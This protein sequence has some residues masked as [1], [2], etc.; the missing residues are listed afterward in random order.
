[1]L[2]PR[3]TGKPVEIVEHLG[4]AVIEG[5]AALGNCA[6]LGKNGHYRARCHVTHS[7]RYF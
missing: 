6:V 1:M 7:M 4:E 3:V 5:L 2:K